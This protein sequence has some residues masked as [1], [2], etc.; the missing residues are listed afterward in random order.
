M[1]MR[2]LSG[3]LAR[4]VRDVLDMRHARREPL[5]RHDRIRLDGGA[6]GDARRVHADRD[7]A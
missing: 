6:D 2:A 4:R 5:V 3:D 1:G 7:L